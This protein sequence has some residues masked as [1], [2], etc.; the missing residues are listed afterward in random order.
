MPAD[1]WL[2]WFADLMPGLLL[3]LQLTAVLLVIGLPL[4]TVFATGLGSRNRAIR[5]VTVTVVEI[6]RGIPALVLLY[7]VYFGL[8]Q[9]SLSLDAFFSASVALGLSFGA[10]SSAA[11]RSGID[12][13]HPGQ[14][15]ASR[16][17]GL[18]HG[19][20]F[21]RVVLP[22]A[23]K[24]VTPPLLGWAIIYF[25]ATSLAFAIAV[26][27]LLSR[28]YTLATQNFQYFTILSMAAVIYAAISIPASLFA[29]YL[30]NRRSRPA[31]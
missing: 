6:S 1:T 27:E 7:I 16:A 8:P 26:P 25:Q 10:Y 24:I 22:Q 12:A 30:A 31:T 11:I 14:R 9:V 21:F 28:A 17:L 13:V 15:E 29:D 23:M 2:I 20:E 3:S 5:Y 19:D 4:G 18:R